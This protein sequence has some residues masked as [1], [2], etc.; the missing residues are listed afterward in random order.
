MGCV[1]GEQLIRVV[2]DGGTGCIELNRPDKRN[3]MTVA[4]W[5]DLSAACDRLATDPAVRAVLVRGVGRSFC[6]GADI[7]A[8]REGDATVKQVVGRAEAKL[9]ALPVPTVAVIHGHC[10]GAGLQIATACDL[11]I[12]AGDATF[13]VPPARLG[14]VYPASSLAA[15]VALI[16]PAATKRLVFTAAP[17]DAAQAQHLGLIDGVATV[18]ELDSAATDLVSGFVGSLLS[19]A[20]AKAIVNEIVDGADGRSAYRR[21]MAVWADSADAVEGPNAFLE[22][23]AAEFSW[24]P[25]Q[26]DN[27]A[28]DD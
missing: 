22:R 7:S 16:G 14:I 9:R 2:V 18:D 20:A 5:N 11:R 25:T 21:W 8:L 27:G 19:H 3:A 12:A 6:T 26:L 28:D 24:H 15:M 10:W 13:A 4:M 17:I 1:D 23:R